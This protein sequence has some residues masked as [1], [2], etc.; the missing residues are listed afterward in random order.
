MTVTQARAEG[1]LARG[2][3]RD[4]TLTNSKARVT[5][6]LD[7]VTIALD[8]GD[9]VR[10]SGVW[11]PWET[12]EDMGEAVANATEHLKKTIGGRYVRLYQTKKQDT[13]RQNRMGHKLAHIERDDGLW[14]QGD[15]LNEGLAF[16]MTS[17]TTPEMATRM[18]AFEAAARKDNK[19]VW[20]NP[21]WRVITPKETHDH[22]GEFRIIEGNVFSLAMRENIFYVNFGRDWQND[23]T[24][25]IPSN[26]RLA[27]ARAGYNIQSL[28]NK[29]IRVRGWI[30]RNNN[31]PQIDITHPQQIEILD[32]YPTISGTEQ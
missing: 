21:R 23:F 16:V 29:N 4:L 28:A 1:A 26:R 32:E 19:G 11:V 18:Y 31:A 27:F 8:N 30:R 2:D 15:L 24:L 12:G 22:T 9:K 25:T 20:D 5:D 7:G 17:E 13:G 14:V 10:L 6:V 3:F